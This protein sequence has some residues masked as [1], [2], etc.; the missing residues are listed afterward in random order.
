MAKKMRP[1]CEVMP[2]PN[3]Q[4]AFLV[5]RTERLRWN[6]SDRYERPFF[7][8]FAGPSGNSLVRMG[9]PGDWGHDH[10]RGV[11]FA[12]HNVEGR[13]FWANNTNNQVRQKRWFV[14]D[15]HDDEAAMAMLLGWY[16]EHNAELMEQEVIIRVRP[17]EANESL[18]SIQSTFTPKGSSLELGKT[19]FGFVAVRVAK[20]ISEYFGG[21]TLTNSEGKVH[22]SEIFGQLAQWVDYSGANGDQGELE[23]ITYFCHP[24]NPMSPCRWHVRED[25]WMGASLCFDEGITIEKSKPLTLRYLMHAHAG[26]YN[27]KRASEIFNDYKNEV[28]LQITKEKV[29]HRHY[30]LKEKKDA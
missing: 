22:E 13:N 9:H 3:D 23:G 19:N 26:A 28:P 10:H 12:H 21:G 20:A 16:D 1:R 15:D 30:Q 5:D 11:W 17:A 7:Y 25:G 27:A 18:L 8:P 29:K 6:F 2:L 4:V 24:S 14:Y